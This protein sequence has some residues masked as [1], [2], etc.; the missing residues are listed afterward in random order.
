MNEINIAHTIVNKR[1]EKGLTQDEL[2]NFIGVSKASVS[3]WETGQSYPDIVLL[4]QL[5]A[6]FNIS[7]DDL[8]GYEPKMTNEDI[9]KL[10]KELSIEFTRKPFDEVMNRCRDITK[11]YFSCFPL[12]LQ[13]GGL[14]INYGYYTVA[15]IDDEQKVSVVEE[16][17]EL[18]IRVKEQS[19]D[20][21]LKHL[22]LHLEATCEVILG[23]PNEVIELL[24]DGKRHATS[25]NEILL[26]QAYMMTEKVDEAKTA[27]QDSIYDS[28][29]ELFSYIPPYLAISI[30]DTG[31]FDEMCKRTMELIKL[32]NVKELFPTGILPFYLA[33]AQGYLANENLDKALEML[34]EYSVV[35]TSITYPLVLLKKDEFFKFVDVSTE[36]LPFGTAELPRDEKSIKQ[37]IIDAVANS[38]A[39]SALNENRQFKS[40]VR[41]LKEKLRD[42]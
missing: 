11:K 20:L 4:P 31:H 10:Y 13:I 6:Y 14:Y 17:K 19:D 28:I 25:S 33:A 27:L 41:K 7:I 35:A 32:F 9:R 34:E 16:A 24:K 5:A 15:S 26:S 1:K 36:E 40:I 30:D 37:S 12:L 39:F 21:E 42:A 23:N 3:K 22:A 29:L 38:P 8:M 2:A 18:F